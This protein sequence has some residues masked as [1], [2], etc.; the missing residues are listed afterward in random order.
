MPNKNAWKCDWQQ[1]AGVSKGAGMQTQIDA[2]QSKLNRA[3]TRAGRDPASCHLIAVSKTKPADAVAEARALGLYHFGENKVQEG[4]EKFARPAA[5]VQ[6][7]TLHL[8]GPLQSNKARA[9]VEHF[10]AIHTV[11]RPKLVNTLARLTQEVGRC[12]QLFIQVNTGEEAQKAGVLPADLAAL[13][14]T[15]R[16]AALPIAGLMCIPPANQAPAPHFAWLKRAADQHGL[17]DLSMGMSGDF[18]AAAELGATY[19]RVGS[20]LFG[21]R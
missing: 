8:I 15:A 13:L 12:P 16:D 14:K 5:R 21:E 4:V 2:I 11:D 7:E 17:K 10:D 6:G 3:L 9:A 19:V 20:A 18:E 1:D